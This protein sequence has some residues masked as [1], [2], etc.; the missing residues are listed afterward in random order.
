MVYCMEQ[1]K[2]L[3]AASAELATLRKFAADAQGLS[4]ESVE[5]ANWDVACESSELEC[6]HVNGM[7]LTI[8][9]VEEARNRIATS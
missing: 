3:P 8:C 4:P 5:L 9:G 6:S 1:A 7:R 2:A